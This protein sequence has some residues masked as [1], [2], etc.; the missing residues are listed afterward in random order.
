MEVD[1]QDREQVDSGER[2]MARE[3][4][5]EDKTRKQPTLKNVTSWMTCR[6]SE[7]A[8]CDALSHNVMYAQGQKCRENVSCEV[9]LS[10][11]ASKSLSLSF[12]RCS[13]CEWE[14]GREVGRGGGRERG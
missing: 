4:E 3:R 5:E 9:Y 13:V 1:A 8:R 2:V 6:W 12:K 11:V 14:G 7:C 10:T